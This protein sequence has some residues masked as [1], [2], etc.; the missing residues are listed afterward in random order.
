M[1]PLVHIGYMKTGSTWLQ[2]RVFEDRGA[3]FLPLLQRRRVID[4]LVRPSPL[5][6]VARPLREAIDIKRQDAEMLGAVPFLSHERLSGAPVSGGFDAYQIAVRLH[7][8]VPDARVLIVV[9]EQISHLL[10]I[11]NEYINQGG[12]CSLERFLQRHERFRFPPFDWNYF[13]FSILIQEY[14]R[15]FGSESVLVLPY[16][17]LREDPGEFAHRIVS[18]AHARMPSDVDLRPLRETRRLAALS[19]ERRLNFFFFRTDT[20]PAAPFHCPRLRG[21]SRLLPSFLSAWIERPLRERYLEHIRS[22]MPRAIA[23]SNAVLV[24]RHT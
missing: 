16:E 5:Y 24:S 9:R 19:I 13:C 18:F 21:L 23:E 1:R 12:A 10:S 7:S 3:G 22:V 6:F 2:R 20:N 17:F 15:R 11:Y 8:L 4:D 14:K